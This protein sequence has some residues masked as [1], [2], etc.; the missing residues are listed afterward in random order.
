MRSGIAEPG[1]NA[2][3]GLTVA[4][5]RFGRYRVDGRNVL[6]LALTDE[7][8]GRLAEAPGSSIR[9]TIAPGT[10]PLDVERLTDLVRR[11]GVPDDRVEVYQT[12]SPGIP[13]SDRG[14]GLA[15][16]HSQVELRRALVERIGQE[17]QRLTS[18]LMRRTEEVGR[19]VAVTGE[20]LGHIRDYLR[21]ASGRATSQTAR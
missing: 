15:L 2:S 11:A 5:D 7:L 12:D 21:N 10:L 8:R 19:A 3:H 14:G 4:M 6:R 18:G 9:L 13:P 20:Y 16:V 17:Q 1:K